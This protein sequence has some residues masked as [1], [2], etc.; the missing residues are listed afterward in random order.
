VINVYTIG[1]GNLTMHTTRW[2]KIAADLRQ[3]IQDGTY[4]P[5]SKLPSIPDLM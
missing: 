3:G 2:A 5:G 4:P 1:T